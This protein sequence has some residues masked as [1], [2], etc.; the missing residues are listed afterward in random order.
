[1]FTIFCTRFELYCSYRRTMPTNVLNSE[2]KTR[3]NVGRECRSIGRTR[4]EAIQN[5][6]PVRHSLSQYVENLV[7]FFLNCSCL[8]CVMSKNK[9]FA[10]KLSCRETNGTHIN[11]SNLPTKHIFAKIQ[12][13]IGPWARMANF[14]FV[15]SVLFLLALKDFSFFQ[16]SRKSFCSLRFHGIVLKFGW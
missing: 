11:L 12:I 1:M 2:D 16:V 9:N 5:R 14:W 8:S 10:T 15:K 13:S 4:R 6:F 7:H 3:T